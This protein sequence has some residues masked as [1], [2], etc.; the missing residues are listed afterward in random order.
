MDPI[1]AANNRWLGGYRHPRCF[2]EE[3]ARELLA[4][5]VEPQPLMDGAEAVGEP[6]RTLPVALSPVVAALADGRSVG[7]AVATAQMYESPRSCRNCR[8]SH[9]AAGRGSDAGASRRA[10]GWRSRCLRGTGHAVVA[11]SG[12]K[13]RLLSDAGE[14]SVVALPFLLAAEDFELVG[15]AALPKVEPTDCWSRCCQGPGRGQRIGSVT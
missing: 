7:G 5:F 11:I 13:I 6:L 10:H 12:A 4:K 3:L 14:A 15:S 8:R 9:F 2:D 1:L